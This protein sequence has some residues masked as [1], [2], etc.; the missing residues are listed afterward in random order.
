MIHVGTSGYTYAYWAS[1]SRLPWRKNFYPEIPAT[2]F[3][4]YYADHLLDGVETGAR[5]KASVEINCTR[6][7]KLTPAMCT[8]WARSAPNLIFTI[9][10]PT[11]F[12]HQKKLTDPDTWWEEDME[13]CV[14]ALG[15]QFGAL[16]FQFPPAFKRT[17]KNEAKLR[18]LF[19]I[20]QTIDCALEFRDLSWFEP[21]ALPDLPRNWSIVW[22]AVPDTEGKEMNFNLPRGLHG[23]RP[24]DLHELSQRMVYFRGHGTSDYS[25]GSYGYTT[26]ART[27]DNSLKARRAF[28]YFNNVDS[29]H[30]MAD[31]PETEYLQPTEDHHVRIV[32]LRAHECIP[33]AI[34]DCRVVAQRVADQTSGYQYDD[35][36]YVLLFLGPKGQIPQ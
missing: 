32:P 4:P 18:T 13:P 34:F 6:Y 29:M 26:L 3:L 15:A 14:Q 22:I 8:K 5:V 35:Q 10:V 9:K 25:C 33:S 11:W 16:L 19:G 31:E 7:R 30:L 28:F 24:C 23:I 27:V 12:T 2:K 21:E 17:P 36:G 20:I 1:T